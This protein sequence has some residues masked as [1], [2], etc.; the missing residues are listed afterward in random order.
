MGLIRQ[1]AETMGLGIAHELDLALAVRL[2]HNHP[3]Q[4]LVSYA[5]LMQADAYVGFNRL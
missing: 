1:A 2:P 5:G 4:H 3:E